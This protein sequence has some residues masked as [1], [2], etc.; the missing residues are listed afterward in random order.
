MSMEIKKQVL[1]INSVEFSESV[2][3]KRACPKCGKE[4]SVTRTI[5]K[6]PQEEMKGRWYV[7]VCGNEDCP[8]WDCGFT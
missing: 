4:D 8:Y 6:E 7:E 3:E 1:I 5:R 2:Q